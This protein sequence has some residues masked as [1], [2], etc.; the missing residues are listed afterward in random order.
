MCKS[1]AGPS[2]PTLFITA[3][4]SLGTRLLYGNDLVSNIFLLIYFKGPETASPLSEQQRS[5]NVDNLFTELYSVKSEWQKLG[6]ALGLDEDRLDE[7]FTI[8][9]SEEECLRVMLEV[10]F[11]KSWKPTWR[12]VANAL[13][14]IGEDQL[15][16]RLYLMSKTRGCNTLIHSPAGVV[17][18]W[19]IKAVGRA[20][21]FRACTRG[22]K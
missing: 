8:N 22:S 9:E 6:E 11:Q 1:I 5:L 10:W 7:I 4:G 3:Q 18:A 15:P 20:T 2:P 14:A 12:D 13:V 19:F 16:G 17:S 21:P